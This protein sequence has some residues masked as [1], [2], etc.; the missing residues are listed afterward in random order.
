MMDTK[1]EDLCT[2]IKA[3]RGEI[4]ELRK[5]IRMLNGVIN[6]LVRKLVSEQ[7]DEPYVFD[8]NLDRYFTA[9]D[10]STRT[11]NALCRANL[12]TLRDFTYVCEKDLDGIRNLGA[13]SKA[14]VLQFLRQNGITIPKVYLPDARPEPIFE[15]G[16]PVI[17]RLTSKPGCYSDSMT[18]GSSVVVT[19]MLPPTTRYRWHLAEY[20]CKDKEG[21]TMTFSPGML[22]KI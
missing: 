16:E 5:D 3:M 15:V 6:I 10:L 4:S 9:K 12:N 14:E 19:E 2:E 22:A 17:L 21:H 7:S 13:R 20:L 1:N 18:A 8:A 11:Y